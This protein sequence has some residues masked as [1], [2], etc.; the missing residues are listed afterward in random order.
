MGGVSSQKAGKTRGRRQR[1]RVTAKTPVP[2]PEA[3]EFIGERVGIASDCRCRTRRDPSTR[4]APIQRADGSDRDR[5]SARRLCADRERQRRA[6]ERLIGVPLTTVGGGVPV[7]VEFASACFRC[8]IPTSD[9]DLR[10]RVRIHG[11]SAAPP[12]SSQSRAVR[13]APA[14]ICRWAPGRRSHSWAGDRSADSNGTHSQPGRRNLRTMALRMRFRVKAASMGAGPLQTVNMGG[15][16]QTV[17]GR[18]PCKPGCS[19]RIPSCKNFVHGAPPTAR[20]VTLLPELQLVSKLPVLYQLI[21]ADDT[22]P[23]RCVESSDLS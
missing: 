22:P 9:T 15:R 6:P 13:S 14:P 3:R 18:P 20:L 8:G 23:S 1:R 21:A 2:E 10:R 16:R 5:H 17:L 4:P 11:R 12:A 7:Q 19:G